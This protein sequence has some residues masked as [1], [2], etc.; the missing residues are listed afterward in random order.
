M[1]LV[2]LTFWIIQAESVLLGYYTIF[3]VARIPR[4]AATGWF[5]IAF[6]FAEP[7]PKGPGEPVSAFSIV[8]LFSFSSLPTSFGKPASGA[9]P[10][11]AAKAK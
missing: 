10:P 2:S 1:G 9:T 4:E 11:P 3:H 5:R 8:G 7:S 6:T